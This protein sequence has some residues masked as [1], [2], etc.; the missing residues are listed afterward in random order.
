MSKK[1]DNSPRDFLSTFDFS[2]EEQEVFLWLVE[3]GYV[4]ALQ[5][6]RTLHLPRTKI[7]RLLDQ[8]IEKKV[9]VMKVDQRGMK[10]GAAEPIAFEQLVGEKEA[11]VRRLQSQLGPLVESLKALSQPMRSSSKVLYYSGK[12][13]LKQVSYNATKAKD[14]LRVYEVDHLSDFLDIEFSEN[15]RRRFVENKIHIRDLTNK[16]SFAGFSE[17]KEMIQ[18][19]SLFRY[20]PKTEL[21]IQ[22]EAMIYNDVYTTYTYTSEEVF[23]VEIYNEQLAQMQKQLH[24]FVWEKAQPMRFTDDR[25]AAKVEQKE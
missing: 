2:I 3:H 21:D 13:G 15:I 9:V 7:Y 25:G 11:E 19:Y 17:V 4:T 22:F 8:L 6:S 5:L 10:F 1:S 23:C 14:I 18:Q 16:M 20:I 12:E 24:D